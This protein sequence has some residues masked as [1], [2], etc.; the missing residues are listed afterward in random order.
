MRIQAVANARVEVSNN[1]AFLFVAAS[2]VVAKR[3]SILDPTL[4]RNVE[5]Q[6]FN[7][8]IILMMTTNFA[9]FGITESGL[10]YYKGLLRIRSICLKAL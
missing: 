7:G 3:G 6:S 10:T 8:A 4:K 5:L 1:K 9:G 2:E